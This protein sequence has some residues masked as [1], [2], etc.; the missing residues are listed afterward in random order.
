LRREDVLDRLADLYN[1]RGHGYELAYDFYLL[2]HAKDSL[3]SGWE[4]RYWEGAHRW[5]ID[6]IINK[7][8]HCWLED[9][10]GEEN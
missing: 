8:A 3:D 2:Y 6:Q 10:A 9:H 5:N 1:G 7:Q 4:Q